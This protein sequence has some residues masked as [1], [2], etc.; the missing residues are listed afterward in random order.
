MRKIF[1][2]AVLVW[3]VAAILKAVVA[4]TIFAFLVPVLTLISLPA[5][6]VIEIGLIP[7]AIVFMLFVVM[8]LLVS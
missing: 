7:V 1:V 5:S 2:V 3:V 4:G 6:I 8:G